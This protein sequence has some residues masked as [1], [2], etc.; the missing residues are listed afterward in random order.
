MLSAGAKGL[1][2]EVS[3]FSASLLWISSLLPAFV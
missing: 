2:E 3:D 1:E